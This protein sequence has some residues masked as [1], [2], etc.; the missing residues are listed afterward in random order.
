[1]DSRHM[2]GVTLR[3]SPLGAGGN[4]DRQNVN[5]DRPLAASLDPPLFDES[6]TIGLTR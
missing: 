6:A 5:L 2:S 1:M 3:K 4:G